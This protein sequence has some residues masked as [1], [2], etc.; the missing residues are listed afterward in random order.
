MNL[1]IKNQTV[2]IALCTYNGEKYLKEQLDS[3]L[4][5]SY[6]HISEI[7]CIDDL[8]TDQSWE[9][10]QAYAE[11]DNRFIIKRNEQNLGY[12]KNFE[13]AISLTTGK[14]IAIADQDDIW[15]VEKI[16]KLVEKINDNL[17]VYSDNEYIDENGKSLNKRFSDMRNLGECTSCL[18]FALINGISGHTML[19]NRKLLEFAQPFNT[20]I[21][22]DY[23][24][25]FHAAQHGKIAFVNQALVKYRQHQTNAIGAMGAT[26][27]QKQ[28]NTI[29]I[30]LEIFSKHANYASKEEKEILKRLASIINNYSLIARLEKVMIFLKHYNSILFFKKRNSSRKACYAIKMFW[31]KL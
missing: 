10:L 13:K 3:I 26:E 17:L 7:V 5:Q 30:Q 6:S 16:N 24:L 11:K 25:A 20:I 23:W 18:N 14:F 21:P 28:T 29:K 4:Q 12:I 27:N 2:S 22:Y 9:I 1:N 31:K 8:S 15:H 19:F